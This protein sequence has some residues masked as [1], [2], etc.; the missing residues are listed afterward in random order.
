M[1]ISKVLVILLF[2]TGYIHDSSSWNLSSKSFKAIIMLVVTHAFLVFSSVFLQMYCKCYFGGNVS[3]FQFMAASVALID[4]VCVKKDLRLVLL[5]SIIQFQKIQFIL[6]Y[7]RY[8]GTGYGDNGNTG[9]SI[10][11][12]GVILHSCVS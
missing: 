1:C 6:V 11:F 8:K 9:N 5:R 10:H 2:G 3:F 12:F 4:K 7:L